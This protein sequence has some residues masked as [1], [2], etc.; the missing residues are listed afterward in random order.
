MRL[1][2]IGAGYV[3]LVSASG[4]ASLGNECICIDVDPNKVDLINKGVAPIYEEGLDGLL[5]RLSSEG[6]IKAYS[7]YS[8]IAGSDVIFI[9]VGTPSRKD[10]S[11]ELDYVKASS[12]KVGRELRNASGF[13]VVVVKS[14]VIPGTTSGF[15][16]P[17]LEKA[18]GKTAG[19]DFGVA[20]MP[21]FLKEGTALKDF[22]EPD[23]LVIGYDD[24]QT[25]SLLK[26]MHTAFNCPIADVPLSTAEMI[27]YASNSFLSTKISFINQLANLCERIGVDIDRVAYG[28]GL[29]RRIGPHFLKAGP[30]FG[31]SCFP[32]DVKALMA[33]SSEKGIEPTLLEAVME[34]NYLQPLRMLELAGGEN[35]LRGRRVAVLGLAFKPDTDDIR[36]SPAITLVEELMKLECPISAYDPKAAD[37]F[38][39]MF[40]KARYCGSLEEALA[41]SEAC[42]IVTDWKEFERPLSYYEGHMKHP[43]IIDSRRILDKKSGK[44]AIYRAIG[45]E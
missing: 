12:E 31:G 18:S 6:K 26:K 30:G 43:L 4:Y 39:K 28:M 36:E 27:K 38:R 15:I 2:F 8:R 13:P 7:D 19:K 16:L 42:F 44:N 29:D 1:S 24:A 45:R 21:E 35:G 5:S 20:M 37:N 3:G 33:F 41:D 34:I 11:I 40:P 23:R 14:T 17:L 25:L 22:L 9:C 10:G 32:K